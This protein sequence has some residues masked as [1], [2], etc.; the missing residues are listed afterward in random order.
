MLPYIIFIIFSTILFYIPA[1]ILVCVFVS[2]AFSIIEEEITNKFP[3]NITMLISLIL[4]ISFLFVVLLTYSI[5]ILEL[6][7]IELLI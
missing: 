2:S 3:Y 1:C 7:K 4:T 6:L 5:D